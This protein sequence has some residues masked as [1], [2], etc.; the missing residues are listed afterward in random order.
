MIAA[1][2][3]G[4]V[5]WRLLKKLENR[6]FQVFGPVPIRLNKP[7]KLLLI[8]RTCCRLLSNAPAPNYGTA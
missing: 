5:Y 3:M 7:Q 1:E 4:S 6:R 2:L 8:F